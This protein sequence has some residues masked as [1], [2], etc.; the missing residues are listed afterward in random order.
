MFFCDPSLS[1]TVSALL[2]QSPNSN[3]SQSPSVSLKPTLKFPIYVHIHGP[4]P[5]ICCLPQ[6]LKYLKL[7]VMT[8]LHPRAKVVRVEVPAVEVPEEWYNACL[9]KC[10]LCNAYL[11]GSGHL[12]HHVDTKHGMPFHV[13]R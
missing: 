3:V 11:N 6:L 5:G 9:F 13:Y 2:T 8:L 7:F 10:S 12:A 4:D 1:T